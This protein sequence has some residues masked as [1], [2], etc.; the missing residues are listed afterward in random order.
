M[1]FIGWMGELGKPLAIGLVLLALTL[2]AIGW[3]T[4]RLSWRWHAVWAWR[5]R[6]RMR[7]MP[8]IGNGR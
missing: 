6:Q 3:I 5:R 8:A 1:Q 2:A 7:G 4:V